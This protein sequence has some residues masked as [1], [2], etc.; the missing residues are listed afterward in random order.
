MEP[1]AGPHKEGRRER[2]REAKQPRVKCE[3]GV[4]ASL[5]SQAGIV[6]K[7]KCFSCGGRVPR[8]TGV[9]PRRRRR[10]EREEKKLF[11]PNQKRGSRSGSVKTEFSSSWRAVFNYENEGGGGEGAV[12]RNR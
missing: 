11:S 3:G 8:D 4:S 7:V 1:F 10:R 5:F 6:E 9:G 2:E 12:Y